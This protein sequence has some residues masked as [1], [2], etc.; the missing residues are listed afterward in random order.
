MTCVFLAIGPRTAAQ[1]SRDKVD[2]SSPLRVMQR[3]RPAT[4][5]EPLTSAASLQRAQVERCCLEAPAGRFLLCPLRRRFDGMSRSRDQ[6]SEDPRTR[7][8]SRLARWPQRKGDAPCCAGSP[9]HRARGAKCA[10]QSTSGSPA[11]AHPRVH[12]YYLRPIED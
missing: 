7:Q 3:C 6:T 12:V 2:L 9:S 5:L 10:E 8:K 4:Q 11:L 1:H